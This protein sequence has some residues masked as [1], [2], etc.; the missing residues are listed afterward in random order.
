[1]DILFHPSPSPV[2]PT[3]SDLSE[4]SGVYLLYT[5]FPGD[6][7]VS[8]AGRSL[9]S[10]LG[11]V[12]LLNVVMELP[13]AVESA[14]SSGAGRYAFTESDDFLAFRQADGEME[15]TASFSD[16]EVAAPAQA[17]LEALSRFRESAL[18]HACS[19]HPELMRNPF[20]VG[21]FAQQ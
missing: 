1:M 13:R 21:S 2:I 10:R 8:H 15:I 18:E 9:S 16:A 3:R 12:P 14:V 4:V 17:V 20:F 19:D 7:E 11:W 5:A 6:I